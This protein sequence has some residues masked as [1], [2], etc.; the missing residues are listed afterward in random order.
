MGI[1]P[2]WNEDAISYTWRAGSHTMTMP[3]EASPVMPLHA[4]H[5]QHI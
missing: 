2:S 4:I 3:Q 5:T 1:T